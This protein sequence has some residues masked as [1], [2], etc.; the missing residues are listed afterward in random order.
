MIA[1]DYVDVD[2]YF[3][4]SK[5]IK[6][7]ASVASVPI[8]R[9][10]NQGDSTNVGYTGALYNSHYPVNTSEFTL[11]KRR[12]VDFSS[13]RTNLTPKVQVAPTPT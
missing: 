4:T 2:F 13:A 7:Q 9:M 5:Q 1:S 10:L 3:L 8:L 12:L 6:T 11:I